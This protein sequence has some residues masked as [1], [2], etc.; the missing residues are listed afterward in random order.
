MNHYANLNV[1]Q[2]GRLQIGGTD[3]VQLAERFGTPLYVLAEEAIRSRCR[4]YQKALA[5]H[6]GDGAIAY[7][8]KALITLAICRIMDEENMWLD[9]A[10]GGELYVALQAGFPAQRILFHGNNKSPEE[11]Q[12]GVD[13]GVGRFVCDNFDELDRLDRKSTL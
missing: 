7:A 4:A 11:L 5:V 10:S 1:D 2:H 3:A 8:G 13:A 12:M 9:V 6:W